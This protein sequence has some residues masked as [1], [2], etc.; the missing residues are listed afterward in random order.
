MDLDEA[1][2]LDL[3][4]LLDTDG[5]GDVSIPEFVNGCTRL[6]GPVLTFF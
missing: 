6:H 1:N 2:A 3:F 5:S 4:E